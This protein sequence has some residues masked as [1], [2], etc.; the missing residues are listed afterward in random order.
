M[1]L[2]DHVEDMAKEA[3]G[4]WRKFENFHW[5]SDAQPNDA[6]NWCV[7]TLSTR[8]TVSLCDKSN[9][10]VIEREM[11]PYLGG[12]A[13]LMCSNHWGFGY[14]NQLAIR[15]KDADGNI[16]EAFKTF[17]EMQLALSDY[18]VLDTSDY[19]EREYNAQHEAI[20]DNCPNVD[21]ELPEDWDDQVWEYFWNGNQQMLE[22]GNDGGS[23]PWLT[24]EAVRAA[25]LELGLIKEDEEDVD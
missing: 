19:S 4:N 17:C 18:P 3:I 15:V 1:D 2:M 11:E 25:L 12:D 8:D 20:R 14:L 22:F 24:T 6:E 13:N 16:T 21:E 23:L 5:Y 9:E 7:V 10:A